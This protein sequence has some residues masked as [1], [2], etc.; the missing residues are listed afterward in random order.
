MNLVPTTALYQE[1]LAGSTGSLAAAMVV[2]LLLG[3]I[4][5]A[6]PGHGK[7][8]VVASLLGS[9]GSL[10]RV[11]LLA[12][13][14]A[15]THTLG[16]LLL[17]LA[18]LSANDALLPARFV[19]FVTLAAD[20]LVVLFGADLVRRA[21][22]ARSRARSESDAQAHVHPHGPEL[23][24][25][26]DHAGA[27]LDLGRGY[28]ISIGI[29]GGLVPNG[30]ALVV[31]LMAIALHQ[32]TLGMLLVGAFGAGIA[33]MLAA[34]GVV[35]VLVQRRGRRLGASAGRAARFAELLPLLSGIAV[36]GVGTV[37]TMGA[38]SA[39]RA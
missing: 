3:A 35:A 39:L 37:L 21:R 36:M 18:V 15:A 2:A 38:L 11:V 17:A 1:L 20:V 29:V 25:H 26:P 28:T 34:V 22:W 30:T 6:S 31:L 10:P 19:P 8:L 32:L 27:G 9:R 23:H 4:H 33:A 24:E 13:T 5:G 7:T 12:L 16:V 14:V